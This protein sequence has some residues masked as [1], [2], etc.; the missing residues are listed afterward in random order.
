MRKSWPTRNQRNR[1]V[2]MRA[3]WIR[4]VSGALFLAMAVLQS[5]GTRGQTAEQ[6]RADWP[7]YRH[8]LAG[9]G[10]SPLSQINV[11]NVAKLASAWSYQ[12]QSASAP[13][14]AGRGGAGQAGS[15]ATPIVVNGVM[16]LP[17]L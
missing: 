13:P 7:M 14:V 6:S 4:G 15:Q 5:S 17:A 9:T 1:S 11:K 2:H 12:L 16:Y 3:T 8:D 10:F